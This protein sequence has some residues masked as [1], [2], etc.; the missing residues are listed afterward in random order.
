MFYICR[1]FCTYKYSRNSFMLWK[2][3]TCSKKK[4]VFMMLYFKFNVIYKLAD[5]S[6]SES[7]KFKPEPTYP[8]TY[9]VPIKNNDQEKWLLGSILTV[10]PSRRKNCKYKAKCKSLQNLENCLILRLTQYLQFG[11]GSI[12]PFSWQVKTVTD[13]PKTTSESLKA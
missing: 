8:S 10:I 4:I 9:L 5:I 1:A 3:Y 12:I 7:Q 11:G 13:L 6:E 2:K